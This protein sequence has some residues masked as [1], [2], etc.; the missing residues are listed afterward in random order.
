[1]VTHDH[2]KLIQ[3]NPAPQGIPLTEE[4]TVSTL[5]EKEKPIEYFLSKRASRFAFEKIV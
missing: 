2:L 5:S 4:G 1:M 3:L